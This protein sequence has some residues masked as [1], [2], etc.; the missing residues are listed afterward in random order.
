MQL[1]YIIFALY[2]YADASKNTHTSCPVCI[3]CN[4]TSINSTS[5]SDEQITTE[6]ISAVLS[7]LLFI[8]E[9]L[10]FLASIK[11]NGIAESIH[12]ILTRRR[13]ELRVQSNDY[14]SI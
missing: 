8:S 6:R 2:V 5:P 13:S 7:I 10:P 11:A 14:G 1:L 4:T 12:M 3:L 9:L